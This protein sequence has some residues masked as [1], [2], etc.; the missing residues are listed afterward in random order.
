[1]FCDIFEPIYGSYVHYTKQIAETWHSSM[2]TMDNPLIYIYNIKLCFKY[3]N[4][5][6]IFIL[7]SSTND[8]HVSTTRFRRSQRLEDGLGG[9]TGRSGVFGGA[10]LRA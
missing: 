8:C 1:M 3:K 10:G 5:L 6:P 9:L 4:I 2:I 7:H